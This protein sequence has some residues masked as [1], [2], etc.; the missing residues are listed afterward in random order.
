MLL[1]NL[2]RVLDKE[3]LH[4]HHST[5]FSD[6]DLFSA[7]TRVDLVESNFLGYLCLRLYGALETVYVKRVAGRLIESSSEHPNVC[8][9]MKIVGAAT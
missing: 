4:L 1:G 7:L 2:L 5:S 6:Q 9:S 8:V 3:F